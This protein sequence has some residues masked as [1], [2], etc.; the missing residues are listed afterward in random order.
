MKLTE[1]FKAQTNLDRIY[2]AYLTLVGAKLPG[3]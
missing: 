2:V 1:V 3:L